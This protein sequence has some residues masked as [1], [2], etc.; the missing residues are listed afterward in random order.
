[1]LFQCSQFHFVCPF[2]IPS[3]LT[4]R[5][6]KRARLYS[7][8]ISLIPP[9]SIPCSSIYA[10]SSSVYPAMRHAKICHLSMQASPPRPL[11]RSSSVLSPIRNSSYYQS[12]GFERASSLAR[13]HTHHPR[14]QHQYHQSPRPHFLF[15]QS[16]HAS[17][18]ST[19]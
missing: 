6:L 1:M 12:S 17:Q 19:L 15:H 10:F 18:T 14:S 9:L 11:R 3:L 8:N 7:S 4:P 2:S 13:P 5:S 16:L